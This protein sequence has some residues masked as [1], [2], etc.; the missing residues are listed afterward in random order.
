MTLMLRVA[1]YK[2]LA[3]PIMSKEAVY[4][5]ILGKHYLLDALVKHIYNNVVY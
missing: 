4:V 1:N 3:S 5:R 2:E